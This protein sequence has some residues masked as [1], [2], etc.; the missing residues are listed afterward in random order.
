MYPATPMH[1]KSNNN[2]H[3]IA[4]QKKSSCKKHPFTDLSDTGA[5]LAWVWGCNTPTFGDL[6]GKFRLKDFRP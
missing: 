1:L 4:S 5:L 6:V 3:V 2:S